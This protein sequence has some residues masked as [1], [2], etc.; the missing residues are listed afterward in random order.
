MQGILNSQPE[1]SGRALEN[2]RVSSGRMLAPYHHKWN[3]GIFFIVCA[4]NVAN[5]LYTV[6]PV[7]AVT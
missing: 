6:E 5:K 2:E 7:L 4:V 1:S 3:V